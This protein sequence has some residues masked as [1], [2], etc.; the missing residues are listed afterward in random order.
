MSL[1]AFYTLDADGNYEP[2]P[3]ARSPWSADMMH[4]RLL[5]GIVARTVEVDDHATDGFRPARLTIDLFRSPTMEPVVVRHERTRDGGRIRIVEVWLAVGGRD[6]ARATVVLLRTGPHPEGNV[7][8][9]A[10]WD[11]PHPDDIAEPAASGQRSISS[12][13]IRAVEG[14][15]MGTDAQ[16]QVWIRDDRTLLDGEPLTPFQRAVLA[17][18][19]ASPLGN[20]GDL[21]LTFINADIT[22]YLGR[23]PD[24]E[25]IGL[26]VGAHIGTDGVAV[27]RCDLFDTEGPVG[28]A[29]VCAVANPRM[30]R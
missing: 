4:G 17:A 18:D 5:A 8:S 7:W 14:R 28:F 30:N 27:S 6:V 12:M 9:R 11:V 23:L 3:E 16:R 15:G 29:D 10:N 26:E 13:Q 22:V 25:W 2:R 19:F 21:G 20:S 24:G 1:D